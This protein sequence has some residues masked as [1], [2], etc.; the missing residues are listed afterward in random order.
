MISW[1]FTAALMEANYLGISHGIVN[2]SSCVS[3]ELKP[4][5]S[6]L[7]S[8]LSVTRSLVSYIF[9]YWANQMDSV[10][11]SQYQKICS[12]GYELAKFY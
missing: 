4:N 6:N 3:S 9:A 10:T 5:T 1:I 12:D 2:M 11:A 7:N 8:W